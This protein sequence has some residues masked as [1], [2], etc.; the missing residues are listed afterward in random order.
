MAHVYILESIADGRY[1]IGST[2]DLEKRLYHHKKGFT[3]TTKR[4]GKVKLVFKQEYKFLKEARI[5]ESKLKKLKIKD[6]IS[7][8]IKEGY[9][10]I[11]V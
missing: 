11:K 3:P 10:K 2:I 8:I 9:I 7:K 5:I 6:Y 1:Y 4:F